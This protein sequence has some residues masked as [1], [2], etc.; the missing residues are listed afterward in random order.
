[1]AGFKF[2]IEAALAPI[3]FKQPDGNVAGF[4]YDVAQAL[5]EELGEPITIIEQEFDALLPALRLR[6]VDAIIA[7]L[8]ATA[9]REKVVDFTA[10]YL[11]DASGVFAMR[12]D[13]PEATVQNLS[14]KK[15]GVQSG[16]VFDRYA[17]QVCAPKGATVLRYG[18]VDAILLDLTAG[19]LD[20]VLADPRVIEEA[21][22]RTD[23]GK[24]FAAGSP[25][26]DAAYFGPKAIAV[27]KGDDRRQKLDE[28][29]EKVK[30]NGVLAKI[31]EKY[32]SSPL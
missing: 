7:F 23:A 20:A 22:L 18:A 30:S 27:R 5:A 26:T 8:D 9:D 2:G 4:D 11:A 19:R 16:S 32:F 1:M 28:A 12:S 3:A 6:K 31:G 13:G 29:L 14:G 25:I 21:F 24:G 17:M 15:V 10:P